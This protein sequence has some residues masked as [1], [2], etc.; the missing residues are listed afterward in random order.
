MHT[1]GSVAIGA[2][3]FGTAGSSIIQLLG[4]DCECELA[5]IHR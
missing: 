3:T 2:V 1:L 5:R 4:G